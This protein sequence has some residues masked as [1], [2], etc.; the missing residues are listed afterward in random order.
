MM[1]PITVSIVTSLATNYFTEFT[2]P[3]VKRFFDRA[4]SEKPEIGE[5]LQQANSSKD[6]EEIFNEASGIVDASANT[7]ELEVIGAF[8]EAV[9]G[10]RFDH[11]SGKVVIQGTEMTA[12]VLVT[13]GSVNSAGSTTIGENTELK[14]NGTRISVGKGSGIYIGGDSQIRQN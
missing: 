5:K 10:I 1:D 2:T 13:G 12:P 11:A 3:V 8:L 9:K 4:I 6:F 7:G 14:S